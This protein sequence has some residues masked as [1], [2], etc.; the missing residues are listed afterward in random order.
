MTATTGFR[1]PR[2]LPIWPHWLPL[3]EQ[4]NGDCNLITSAQTNPSRNVYADPPNQALTNQVSSDLGVSTGSLHVNLQ[5]RFG[6][7]TQAQAAGFMAADIHFL[8][9]G[10]YDRGNMMADIVAQAAA[11]SV[12]VIRRPM[13][14][15]KLPTRWQ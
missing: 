2:R 9:D 10:Y 8:A 12:T 7:F 3:R 15:L 14:D 1:L 11:R 4:T 13:S 6:T 5:S